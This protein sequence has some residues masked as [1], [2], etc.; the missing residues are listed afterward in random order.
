MQEKDKNFIRRTIELADES[1]QAGDW[2]FGAVLVLGDVV[3]AE[4]MNMAKTELTEHAEVNAVRKALEK[5]PHIDFAK[6]TLYSN[7]EPCPMCSFIV[8][9]YGIGRVVYALHS[10]YWGGSS[11]WHILADHIPPHA[12]AKVR[13]P[14]PPEVVGGVLADEAAKAFDALGWKM[15]LPSAS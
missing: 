12:F 11:R 9:E 14:N 5:D 3:I 15:H 4:A 6:C 7:F 1:V 13:N 2:P 8:R 10:P